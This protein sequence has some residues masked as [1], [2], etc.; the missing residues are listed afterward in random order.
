MQS[1]Y[2]ISIFLIRQLTSVVIVMFWHL[3]PSNITLQVLVQYGK[4]MHVVCSSLIN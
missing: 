1:D 3:Y 2:L 4:P